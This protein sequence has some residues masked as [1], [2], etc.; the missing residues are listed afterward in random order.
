M[1]N[2]SSYAIFAFGFICGGFL[3]VVLYESIMY[4]TDK[5]KRNFLR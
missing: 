5:K 3:T 2:M 1:K 4:R